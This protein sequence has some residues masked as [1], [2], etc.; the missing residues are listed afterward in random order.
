MIF[1]YETFTILLLIKEGVSTL[2]DSGN[3]ECVEL[4][5]I[6]GAVEKIKGLGI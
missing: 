2:V 5:E 3:V 6:Y 1:H 4:N